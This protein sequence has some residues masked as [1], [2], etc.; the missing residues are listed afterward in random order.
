M[1]LAILD[2][3]FPN[4]KDFSRFFEIK[5]FIRVL[6][7]KNIKIYTENTSHPAA[8]QYK[9][10]VCNISEFEESQ[11][12][13]DCVYSYD[14]RLLMERRI[15]IPYFYD[16]PSF[17]FD[18]ELDYRA[19]EQ[20]YARL[21]G[22][23]AV[24][25]YDK[26]LNKYAHW[27]DLNSY[28]APKSVDTDV[29][30]FNKKKYAVPY[31]N[32]LLYDAANADPRQHEL[33]KLMR[34]AFKASWDINIVH[35]T[36]SVSAIKKALSDAHICLQLSFEYAGKLDTFPNSFLATAMSVGCVGLA[37]NY[38]GNNTNIMFDKVHY[39]RLD[40][41]FENIEDTAENIV[42]VI[43]YVDRRREKLERVSEDGSKAISKYFN[44]KS[45]VNLKLDVLNNL[46]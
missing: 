22:A 36:D 6:G 13:F 16:I 2:N 44:I 41:I 1:K 26:L 29:F 35:Y 31:L 38:H 46:G 8:C 3:N 12:N 32:I 14:P 4:T 30:Q 11:N 28:W 18:N 42:Q 24:F 34:K 20:I 17:C 19:F 45:I 10:Y 40:D 43:K 5:E 15:K 25:V 9:D 37:N 7:Y 23:S 39:F 21:A 27:L 33:V